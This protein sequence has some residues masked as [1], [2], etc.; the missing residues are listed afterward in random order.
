MLCL[1]WPEN[2][3][4]SKWRVKNYTR[5]FPYPQGVALPDLVTTHLGILENQASTIGVIIP[6]GGGGGVGRI[7]R[8]RHTT[9][10]TSVNI[11]PSESS[12]AHDL[13]L[14]T[15]DAKSLQEPGEVY[16]G[17]DHDGDVEHLM[18]GPVY[19]ESVRIPPFGD[20]IMIVSQRL[21]LVDNY[22]G[23]C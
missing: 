6:L 20:L 8:T 17:G 12:Q 11:A 18:T 4:H 15:N 19:I 14:G 22:Q 2:T 9:K 3:S 16:P 21:S 23:D 1:V 13:G 7:C 10:T 5:S